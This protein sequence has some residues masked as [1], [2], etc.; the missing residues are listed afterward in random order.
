MRRWFSLFLTLALLLSLLPGAALA[1]G[2]QAPA[3]DT[4]AVEVQTE[5]PAEQPPELPPEPVVPE[6]NVDLL[7]SGNASVSGTISLPSGASVLGDGYLFVNL[8]TPPVL[9]QD[10]QVLIESASV[11]G[12]RIFLSKGQSSCS[13]SLTGVEPGEYLLG[14]NSYLNSPSVLGGTCFFNA[15]GTVAANDCDA[16]PLQVPASGCTANVTLPGAPRSIS[17]TLVFDT[18]PAADTEFRL[19]CYDDSRSTSYS[20]TTTLKAGSK[21]ADFSIGVGVGQFPIQVS[22]LETDTNAYYNIYGKATKNYEERMLVSTLEESVSGVEINCTSLLGS[23]QSDDVKVTVQLPAPL[24]ED[25]EYQIFQSDEDGHSRT[26][27]TIHLSAGDSTF[28]LPLSVDAGERFLVGYCDVTN[29]FSYY[30]PSTG[31]RYAAEDGITTQPSQAKIFTGGE[32]SS[33]TIADPTCYTV[34]GTL[35]REGDV[36]P[37]QAAYVMVLRS[38][39][40]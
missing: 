24:T 23:I 3:E 40:S 30:Y 21:T 27:Y 4:P 17:G 14:V 31:A 7:A 36:L 2:E 34:T 20:T 9:D 25:R 37:S 10:G 29:C 11:K 6:E 26:S 8:Y 19:F 33:I 38:N 13:Y 5:V 39:S 18:A 35:T 1:A 32:V 12:T 22:N 15:D 16:V 28:T